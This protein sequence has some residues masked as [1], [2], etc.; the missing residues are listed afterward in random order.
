MCGNENG[1][2]EYDN[3]PCEWDTPHKDTQK[4]SKNWNIANDE[5]KWLHQKYFD[6]HLVI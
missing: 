5:S 6:I 2:N 1:E 4:I 3:Q